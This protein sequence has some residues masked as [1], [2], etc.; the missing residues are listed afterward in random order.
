MTP[1][2]K[3]LFFE[4]LPYVKC[5]TNATWYL[6]ASTY[7]TGNS[8]IDNSVTVLILYGKHPLSI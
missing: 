3:T 7:S 8:L 1:E 5:G 6:G 4:E 2:K